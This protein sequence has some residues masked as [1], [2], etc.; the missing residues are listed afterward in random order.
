MSTR[1]TAP[2]STTPAPTWRYPVGGAFGL[3]V[4]VTVATSAAV[5]IDGMSRAFWV[6][7][8]LTATAVVLALVNRRRLR[9]RDRC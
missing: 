4:L 3:A 5:P 8:A 7:G 1:A 6:A 2:I 9:R